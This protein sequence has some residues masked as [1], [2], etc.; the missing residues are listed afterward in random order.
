MREIKFRAW[1]INEKSFEKPNDLSQYLHKLIYNPDAF[2]G[3]VLMQFTG[4]T[5]VYEGDIVSCCGG[6]ETVEG[7][8]GECECLRVIEW[9]T[10]TLQWVA[11]CKNCREST[12]LY[13]F[14]LNNVVGNIYQNPELLVN[15]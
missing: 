1:D 6:Y 13:E 9:D 12:P 10:D 5:G 11:H 3:V 14:D 2:K 4:M 8:S 15:E 7:S